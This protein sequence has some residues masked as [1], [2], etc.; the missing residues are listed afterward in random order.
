MHAFLS[1][2]RSCSCSACATAQGASCVLTSAHAWLNGPRPGAPAPCHC[3]HAPRA[4]RSGM[5][6]CAPRLARDRAAGGA[7][8]GARGAVR[9]ACAA[10]RGRQAGHQR[11]PERRRAARQ[12]PR[13]VGPGRAGRADRPAAALPGAPESACGRAAYRARVRQAAQAFSRACKSTKVSHDAH[14][15]ALSRA[16]CWLPPPQDRRARGPAPP[17]TAPPTRRCRRVR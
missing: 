17:P 2:W 14:A 10:R 12:R 7:A 15:A 3:T 13:R 6:L 5:V 16:S 9:A 8:A 1:S 11:A 4:A